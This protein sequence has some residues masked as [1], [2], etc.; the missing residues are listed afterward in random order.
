MKKSEY[1]AACMTAQKT[2][3]AQSV[4]NAFCE[5][6]G[7]DRNMAL[8]LSLGF[9]GGMGHT[10]Q[11]CGAVTAAYMV[12]G[13]QQELDPE[14]PKLH[15]DKVYTM[16]QEFNQRFLKLHGSINCTV[17]LGCDLSTPEGEAAAREK[18]LSASLCPRFV[19]DAVEIVE[20]MLQ[21]T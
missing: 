2:N 12:L 17:L 1:A 4:I 19:K 8:K 5:E 15:R 3:C 21:G 9:G 20:E 11:T 6:S 18:G 14:N 16:V 7:L 13:L 10:G